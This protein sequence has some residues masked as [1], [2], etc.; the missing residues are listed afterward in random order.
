MK[1][2][3]VI[4]VLKICKLMGLYETG[5]KDYE[6]FTNQTEGSKNW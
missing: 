1:S 3:K 5:S 4:L 6:G 2:F